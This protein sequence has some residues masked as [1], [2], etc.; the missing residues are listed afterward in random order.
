MEVLV[1]KTSITKQTQVS[2]AKALLTSI[3]AIEAWNFDLEDCDNILR[4]V[5]KNLS[6]RYVEAVLQTAGFNC[7]ELDY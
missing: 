1:F 5:A 4:I 7:Q 6:P 3:P 2:K